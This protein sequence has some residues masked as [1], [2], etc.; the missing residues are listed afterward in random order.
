MLSL[1][2]FIYG[3]ND[4]KD[5]NLVIGTTKYMLRKNKLDKQQLDGLGTLLM[6]L[7]YTLNETDKGIELIKDKVNLFYNY[8]I[9]N[10]SFK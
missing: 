7:V 10:L 6:R 2:R 3:S 9:L 1:T 5:L 8:F 4:L